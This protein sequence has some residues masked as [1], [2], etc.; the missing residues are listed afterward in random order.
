MISAVG[1][2]QFGAL[3]IVG[4]AAVIYGFARRHRLNGIARSI[5]AILVAYGIAQVL[6][7]VFLWVNH[8]AFPLN[9]E[10]ME[11]TVLQHVKRAASGL[12]IYVAPSA[13]FVALAYNPLYYY[14]SVPFTWILGSN[15]TALRSVA[16]L[17]MFGSEVVVF[18]AVRRQTGSYWWS[19]IA[20]G[21]FAA[22]YRAMDTY[23]DNAHA[24]SWLLL[25]VLLG[26]YL[27]DLNRSRIT[28]TVA[29]LLFVSAFWFKQPGGL[30]A[31]G[32]VVYL[33]WR[34]GWRRSLPY[35]FLAIVL[36]PGLYLAAPDW[37]FGAWFRY[38]TWTVPRQWTELSLNAVF[39][40]GKYRA[41]YFLVLAS[42][43]SVMSLVTIVRRLRLVSIWYFMLPVALLSGLTSAFDP[44]GNNN[45]FI[46]MG[47]WFIVTGVL[48]LKHLVDRYPA[49]ERHG[50]HLLAV[51]ASFVLLLYDPASVVVS[52]HAEES[53]QDMVQ[54]LEALDGHVYAPW[55]GQLADSYQF[56]PA[57]HWVPL[58]DIIRG[59]GVNTDGHPVTRGIL[60]AVVNPDGNPYVLMNYPLEGD[61]LMG[62]L[63]QYYVLDTDLGE[64]Y[65]ALTTLPKRYNL[66]WPRYLY[67]YAPSE[68]MQQALDQP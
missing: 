14:L 47:L 26:S 55:L 56:V 40:W 27:V 6:Y 8:I 19:L 54:F 63:A 11:L 50:G 3:A 29:V 61:K 39:R 31:I 30:F 68:A 13:D 25:L 58:E 44:W 10:A 43:G 65:E 42:V 51:G 67:R 38:F 62:F 66:A 12:P 59:P 46:V 17:G 5:A 21:L 2:A 37:L 64:R 23:L 16:I 52:S 15:L 41:R 49:F 7:V 24:D 48:A 32:G 22:A 35:W 9:L 34:D 53:Y 33:T 36:G 18:L 1:V 60:Q 28:N 57:V 4:A 20:V 45:I